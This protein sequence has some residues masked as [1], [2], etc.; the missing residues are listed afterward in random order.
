M[1]NMSKKTTIRYDNW[2][3]TNKLSVETR[4]VCHH[5]VIFSTRNLIESVSSLPYSW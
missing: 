5:F 1:K 4:I 2:L 3:S